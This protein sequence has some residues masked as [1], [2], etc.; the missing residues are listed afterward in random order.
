MSSEKKVLND[1]SFINRILIIILFKLFKTSDLNK[2]EKN[3]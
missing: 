3:K 1:L 2:E